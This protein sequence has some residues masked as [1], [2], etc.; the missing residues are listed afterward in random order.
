MPKKEDLIRNRR[1]HYCP[2]PGN[3]EGEELKIDQ[4]FNAGGTNYFTYER[5]TPGLYVHFS[6]VK[7]EIINAERG[8]MSERFQAYASGS[9][10]LCVVPTERFTS[11]A[12]MTLEAFVHENITTI[13]EL[14]FAGDIERLAA[15]LRTRELPA[16]ESP[17]RLE[18]E[19]VAA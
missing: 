15:Y 5:E 7:R 16:L 19:L 6:P 13:R 12:W 3:E 4:T 18:P 17:E 10:K 14:Y 2:I 1:K 9:F 11:K 8:L